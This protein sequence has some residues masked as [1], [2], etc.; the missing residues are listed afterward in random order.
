MAKQSFQLDPDA[1]AYTD[2]EIVGKIN[3][4]TTGAVITRSDSVSAAARPIEAGEVGATELEHEAYTTGEKAKLT[5]IED[6]ATADQ[7][8][9]EIKTA[10]EAEANAYTDTK[11]T[12]LTSIED[13]ATTDQTGTEIRDAVVALADTERKIIITDPQTGEFPILAIQRNST[14]KLDIDYDDVATT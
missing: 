3:S 8:G 9:T 1:V 5:G 13:S 10:Y 14:G 6:S 7:T 4:A 12:K 2:D 11:D